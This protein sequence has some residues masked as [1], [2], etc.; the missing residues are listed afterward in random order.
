[1]FSIFAT[2]PTERYSVVRAGAEVS[3][4]NPLGSTMSLS[5]GIV[6]LPNVGKS[7]LF[8][9]LTKKG[10]EAANYP[11][12]TIDPN[13][14]VVKVP[15]FRLDKLAEVSK[16][17]RII[18][19]TI[20]FVDIAGLVAGAHK[21]EGLGNQ[22]LAHIREC[23]AICE[24]VRDF[25]DKNIIH[26]SGQINPTEDKETINLELIFADLATVEKRLDKMRR[27]AKSGDKEIKAGLIILEKI[28][29][30]LSAGKAVRE[31]QFEE[32]EWP[33]VKS[34][35]LLTIKPILY[36]L[37]IDEASSSDALPGTNEEIIAINVKLEEEIVNLP[38]DEQA[39]YIKELG[40]KQSGL[41]RLIQ[42]AYRLLG[43]DT[44]FTT[45]PD[46]TRAWTIKQGAKAPQAAGEIHTDFIKGFIRAEV[47]NWGKFIEC[48]SEAKARELGLIRTEGKGYIVKD[49]DVCNFL[50]NR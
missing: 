20:E 13:V 47:I 18:P 2:R 44:F 43:L 27:E 45:G 7:T 5:I 23:D 39:E 3:G 1:M 8:N 31:L 38:E 24:V 36:L 14:G 19:T 16:P 50:V 29:T 46:E 15:D 6:G 32:E 34:L 41:D 17:A 49:G 28:F 11:F 42:S 33:F 40:L 37:N 48:G 21:G 22:F 30:Q 35:N 25:K 4:S 10:V 12:C 9:L 26:V